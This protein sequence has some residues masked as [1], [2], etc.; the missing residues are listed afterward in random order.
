MR[1]RSMMTMGALLAAYALTTSVSYGAL[2]NQTNYTAE[3]TVAGGT[4]TFIKDGVGVVGGNL[5]ITGPE[6]IDLTMDNK[7]DESL[8]ITVINGK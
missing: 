4:D 8:G 2:Q 1:K 7:S 3:E 5:T 6:N